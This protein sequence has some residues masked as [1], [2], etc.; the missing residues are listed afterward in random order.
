MCALL[1]ATILAYTPPAAASQVKTPGSHV[2]VRWTVE[3]SRVQPAMFEAYQGE[4]LDLEATLQSYGKPFSISCEAVRIYWQTNGMGS[5]WWSAPAEVRTGT[6]GERDTYA[7]SWTPDMDVGAST[8]SC[9]IGQPAGNFRAAFTLR[10]RPSPGATPN[11]LDL[12]RQTID[13]ATVEILNPPWLTSGDVVYRAETIGTR[14]KW[15]DSNGNIWEVTRNFGDWHYDP[16]LDPWGVQPLAAIN[17]YTGT[18][19]LHMVDESVES[20]NRDLFATHLEFHGMFGTWTADRDMHVATN[21]VGRLALTNETMTAEETVSSIRLLNDTYP[22]MRVSPPASEHVIPANQYRALVLGD[23]KT[24]ATAKSLEADRILVES[25]ANLLFVARREILPD[26]STNYVLKSFQDHLSAVSPDAVN[27]LIGAYLPTN[28]GGTVTGE[29]NVEGSMRVSGVLDAPRLLRVVTSD[30]EARGFTVSNG[31][32]RSE[33]GLVVSNGMCAV[34]CAKAEIGFGAPRFHVGGGV[35]S[36]TFGGTW[37]NP[38]SNLDSILDGRISTALERGGFGSLGNEVNL[39]PS[40]GAVSSGPNGWAS[41]AD[42]LALAPV[43]AALAVE[44]RRASTTSVN[45]ILKLRN[46]C[47]NVLQDVLDCSGTVN[48]YFPLMGEH[49]SWDMC[50]RLSFGI[51]ISHDMVARSIVWDYPA[52][53]GGYSFRGE[54]GEEL[55]SLRGGDLVW[56][57]QVGLHELAVRKTRFGTTIDVEQ[58]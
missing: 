5:A 11:T 7:A 14:D 33:S 57:Q 6:S 4:A 36:L 19:E 42:V 50:Q 15:T 53:D 27:D 3:T 35:K 24:V 39:I 51:Y 32:L 29:L 25:P 16:A 2:P 44:D 21:L 58:H 45:G 28:G 23:A 22:G 26:G 56:F 49:D 38:N 17:Y 13:F 47:V 12:P 10:L 52:E 18:W 46:N 30:I 55:S 31:V 43:T 9:F 8:Y 41:K 34:K 40:H 20:D 54:T 48:V 37:D 1:A